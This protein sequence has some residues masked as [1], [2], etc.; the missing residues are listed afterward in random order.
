VNAAR[1]LTAS[2][3]DAFRVRLLIHPVRPEF[4]EVLPAPA[5]LRRLW[6]KGIHAMTL[7]NRIYID[8]GLLID[9]L[10]TSG[11]LLVHE[12]V[13]VRQWHDLGVLGFL[14]RY[15]GDYLRGRFKGIGHRQAY[16][17]IGL[18]QEARRLAAIFE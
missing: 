15:L 14:R 17:D 7:R 4:V 18:E 10:S 8:P 5:L 6:G 2:G 13:H 16:L 3:L 9:S 12:L 1:L 11:G